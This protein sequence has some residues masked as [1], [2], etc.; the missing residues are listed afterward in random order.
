MCRVHCIEH[1]G[2]AFSGVLIRPLIC[3]G[4]PVLNDQVLCLFGMGIKLI[5]IDRPVIGFQVEKTAI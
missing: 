5:N 4:K 1:S 3:A 2:I